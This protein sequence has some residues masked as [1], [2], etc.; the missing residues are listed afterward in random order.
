VFG[1]RPQAPDRALLARVSDT[2]DVD[3]GTYPEAALAVVGAY[4]SLHELDHRPDDS[5]SFR[6]L[7][8]LAR[9]AA[10]Q[11]ALD[12][13]LAEGTLSIPAGR[14]L[15]KVVADGLDGKLVVNGALADLYRL[16]FWLRRSGYRVRLI[17]GMSTS[18][19]LESVRMP[20]GV[21]A[22][23]IEVCVGVQPLGLSMKGITVLLVERR[24]EQ[25][26]TRTYAL[27][28]VRREFARIAAFL[29]AD[30]TSKDETLGIHTAMSFRFGRG[31]LTVS[32]HL[33]RKASLGEALGTMTFERRHAG[34]KK[35]EKPVY[36]KVSS[37]GELAGVLA[38]Q[39]ADIAAR[40]S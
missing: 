22:P 35:Q 5:S 9:K 32:N 19:G 8:T 24:D 31:W 10:M 2:A 20:D 16:A 21:C 11:S 23:G 37:A 29:F 33:V 30:V 28:T 34:Q 15:E 27:R 4:A 14:S 26:G 38:K 36:V 7:D 17:N 40:A 39:F 13:L 3:L 18:K 6:R 1:R 12:Q 25:A